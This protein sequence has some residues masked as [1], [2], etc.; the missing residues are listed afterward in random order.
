MGNKYY[1]YLLL[2]IYLLLGMLNGEFSS[3]KYFIMMTAIISIYD[4]YHIFILNCA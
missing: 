1:N 2:S 3:C 4:E